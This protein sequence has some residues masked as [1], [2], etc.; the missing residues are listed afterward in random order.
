MMWFAFTWF[1]TLCRAAWI[2]RAYRLDA[3]DLSRFSIKAANLSINFAGFST[4]ADFDLSDRCACLAIMSSLYDVVSDFAKYNAEIWD[5]TRSYQAKLLSPGASEILD[6]LLDEKRRGEI[7]Y[8]GLDRGVSA[9][10]I[11]VTEF[12]QL[13]QLDDTSV[14]EQIGRCCQIAD[15]LIDYERDAK[16]EHLNYLR[17]DSATDLTRAYV[18]WDFEPY[19]SD[20]P[21]SLVLRYA[22]QRAKRIAV[23]ELASREA[24]QSRSP[25]PKVPHMRTRPI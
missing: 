20:K 18:E 4:R 14:I 15:D 24:E 16:S 3:R 7:G 9:V 17:T 10:K 12:G 23:K 19:L 21:L 1:R 8:Y 13:E 25:S 22:L 5:R 11:I 6:R 2:L